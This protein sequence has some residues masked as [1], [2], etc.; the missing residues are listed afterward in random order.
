MAIGIVASVCSRALI[1]YSRNIP[2]KNAL[3]Y[4][5]TDI[6]ISGLVG[7]YL[8]RVNKD[9]Q[10]HQEI[11]AP[12]LIS[13]IIGIAS[14][15]LVMAALEKPFDPMVA[16][17]LNATSFIAAIFARRLGSNLSVDL[18]RNPDTMDDLALL[19]I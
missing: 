2:E 6:A 10:E 3:I 17:A 9:A 11:L 13:R 5:G 1:S 15:L 19:L 4:N 7:L 16:I 12:L 14:G 8:T 18:V